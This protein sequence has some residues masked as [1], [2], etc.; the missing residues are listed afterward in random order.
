METPAEA[1]DRIDSAS[2]RLLHSNIEKARE[3]GAEIVRL[4]GRDTVDALLDFARSH[5]VRHILIGRTEQ[6][7]WRRLLGRDFMFRMVR[8]ADDF[9]L[10]LVGAR[11]LEPAS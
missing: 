10:Y 2:Q 1:P 11:E 7:I 9:D 8:E 5:A 6:P 3:L 4:Q